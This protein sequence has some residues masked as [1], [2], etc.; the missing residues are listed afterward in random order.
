MIIYY[1]SGGLAIDDQ[2]WQFHRVNPK[3]M[4]LTYT[5]WLD[6]IIN[7]WVDTGNM[8]VPRMPNKENTQQPCNLNI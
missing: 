2:I 1:I 3:Q 4:S 7:I 6:L 8:I 5:R